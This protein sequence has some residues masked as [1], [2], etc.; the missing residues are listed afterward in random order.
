MSTDNVRDLVRGHMLIAVAILMLMGITV[1]ASGALTGSP[2]AIPII[3]SLSALQVFLVG[4]ILMHL[5]AERG[6]IQN[7]VRFTLFFVA[8]MVVL[9]ALSFHD[10]YEG[11]AHTSAVNAPA[12]TEEGAH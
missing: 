11:S 2:R 9:T 1:A 4:A 8:A 3:L 7:L 5:S 6:V 10:L 12:S